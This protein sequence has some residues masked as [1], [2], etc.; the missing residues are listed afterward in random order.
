MWRFDDA[1]EPV[2][3][4][5]SG[6]RGNALFLTQLICRVFVFCMLFSLVFLRACSR[7]RFVPCVCGLAFVIF[8]LLLLG[9]VYGVLL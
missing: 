5:L 8:V 7:L 3:R 2:T 4:L 1:R 9:V 6:L